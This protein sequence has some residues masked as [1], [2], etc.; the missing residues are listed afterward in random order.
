MAENNNYRL[1]PWNL[2]TTCYRSRILTL[3]VV[4]ILYILGRTFYIP[5]CEQYFYHSFAI[6]ILRNTS[7]VF[8]NGSFCVSNDLITNYTRNNNSYKTVEA[9]SSHLLLY[10]QTANTIPSVLVTV[11]FG[12]LTGRFGRKIGMIFPAVGTVLQGIMSIFII[13]YAL[14][15]Y[16]FILANFVGGVFGNFASILAA[17]FSYIADV[18]SLRWRSLRVGIVES[19]LAFGACAGALLSG[20]WLEKINCNF[21]PPL[22]FFAGCN[23]FIVVYVIFV[24]PESLSRNER[25]KLQLKNPQGVKQYIQGFKLYLGSLSLSSTWKLYVATIAANIMVIDIFGAQLID[26]YF[27]KAMPFDFNPLKIG[28]Y[29]SLR[30][31][32]QGLA[33]IFFVAVLVALK[34]SDVLIMLIAVLLHSVCTMLIGFANKTWELYASNV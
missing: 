27:L 29:Q 33:N 3:E 34:V 8:P 13:R 6:P 14:S 26:V 24:V 10:A 22:Y 21:I 30:S 17:S 18:S 32:S 28:I 15:P 7:F 2:L 9:L 11:L 16:Y 12:P 19:A 20:Y 1:L 23:F 31:A 5:L 4:V 25:E